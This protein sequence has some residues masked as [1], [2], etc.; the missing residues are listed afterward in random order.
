MKTARITTTGGPEVIQFV[1]ET[2]AP[3]GPGEVRVAHKAVGLNFID[4]YHRTGLYPLP[5]P[6]GLG[7]EAAGVIEAL[8]EGVGDFKVGQRVAYG[9]GPIGAYAQ[10]R[11][12]PADKLVALPDSIADEL[13]AAMMLKGMTARFLLKQTY[14]VKPGEWVLVHAAAGGVGQILCQWATALGARVIG[15]AGGPQKV[16]LAARAGAAHVIDYTIEDVAARVREITKGQGV[17]VSYDGVGQATLMAS[18][19]SLRPRGLL[20]SFGNASGPIKVLDLGLLSA[21]GSL[22][23][24]RPTLMTHVS[25]PEDMRANAADLFAI[26]ASGA[27]K[28]DIAQRYPLLGAARAHADLAARRTTGSTVLSC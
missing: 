13:A 19:D 5:M 10:A 27:V 20:V 7:L 18:L 14:P 11:N 23:V 12:M 8:G 2:L 16:A 24:T 6:T 4:I 22:Y 9:T 25:T 26:M 28:I 21:R 1:D 3:P 15:A 17:S